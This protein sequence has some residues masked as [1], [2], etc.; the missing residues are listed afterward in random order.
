MAQHHLVLIKTEMFLGTFLHVY[1]T[2][3]YNTSNMEF[4]KNI[5]EHKITLYNNLISKRESL[6]SNLDGLMTFL[7][8]MMEIFGPS[9]LM[10]VVDHFV[11]VYT[12]GYIPKSQ[13]AKILANMV[14]NIRHDKVTLQDIH[15]HVV[16]ATRLYEKERLTQNHVIMKVFLSIGATH[17]FCLA[18]AQVE[19][20]SLEEKN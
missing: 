9:I 1:N 17:A 13:T 3:L 19:L 12:T 20:Y 16:S 15:N 14:E 2:G 10:K 18:R 4:R 6:P 7:E 5:V 11:N 8:Y